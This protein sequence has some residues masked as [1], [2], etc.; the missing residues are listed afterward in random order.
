MKKSNNQPKGYIALIAVL[1]IT[2][3]TLSI[4]L[5]VNILSIG[6]T[7]NGLLEQQSGQSFAL[8]ESCLQEAYLRLERDGNFTDG[9]LKTGLGSCSIKVE[10]SGSDRLVTVEAN[11]NNIIR[12][13]TSKASLNGGAIT[14]V[15]WQE[16]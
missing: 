9:Q 6:E 2:V 15:G 16:P 14:L 11:V 13:I 8:A 4:G 3:V 10:A 12:T 5:T 7:Q 1:I